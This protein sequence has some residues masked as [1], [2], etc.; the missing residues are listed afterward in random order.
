MWTWRMSALASRSK[1]K[2]SMIRSAVFVDVKIMKILKLWYITTEVPGY[3]L[4]F[5]RKWLFTE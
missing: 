1:S 2:T 5:K 4:L 3:D